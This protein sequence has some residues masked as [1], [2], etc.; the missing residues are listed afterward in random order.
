MNKVYDEKGGFYDELGGY[1][2]EV[3]GYHEG[4]TGTS[5]EGEECGECSRHTCRGCT[6]REELVR[7]EAECRNND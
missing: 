2:D 6:A 7:M 4:G 1:H 3:G 5:P